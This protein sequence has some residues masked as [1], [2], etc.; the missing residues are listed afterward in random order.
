MGIDTRME[1]EASMKLTGEPASAIIAQRLSA[2]SVRL[3]EDA[4]DAEEADLPEPEPPRELTRAESTLRRYRTL[5]STRRP[6]RRCRQRL[7][8]PTPTR[9]DRG[10]LAR[11][12]PL[13][14]DSLPEPAIAATSCSFAAL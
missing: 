2:I 12:I 11:P 8:M 1:I 14:P 9:P 3:A 6:N 13:Q 5:A 7:S 4:A 10:Q